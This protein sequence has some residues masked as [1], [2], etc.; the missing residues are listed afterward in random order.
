[1]LKRIT[2]LS[3]LFLM[4][5]CQMLEKQQAKF[6]LSI[7]VSAS[8]SGDVK[9]ESYYPDGSKVMAGRVVV[10]TVND[11]KVAD[12]MIG[13]DGSVRFFYSVQNIQLL[14][15]V[16]S[17]EGLRGR[18]TLNIGQAFPGLGSQ[19]GFVPGY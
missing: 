10:K 11:R 13:E 6:P 16:Q 4:A 3:L 8:P 5:G 18:R 14:I 2:V 7:V 17:E 9:V 19:G 1:M 12:Q 15:Q